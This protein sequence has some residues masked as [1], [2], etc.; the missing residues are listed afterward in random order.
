MSHRRREAESSLELL[1]DTICDTLSSILF[2]AVLV[3][4]MLRMTSKAEV[5]GS[6]SQVSEVEQLDLERQQ[7]ELQ[8][9]IETLR[10]AATAL[11]KPTD[12]VEPRIAALSAELHERRRIHQDLLQQ[13][14]AILD[15]IGNRQASINEV[16]R[17]IAGLMKREKDAAKRRDD[18]K[19]SLKK[20]IASRSQHVEYSRVR[21]TGKQ[22]IQA[23]LRYGRFYIW[24]KHG[25]SGQRLGLN[26]D[27]F[28]VLSENAAEVRSTPMPFAGTVAS[29]T[30]HAAQQLVARLIGFSPDRDYIGVLVWQDSFE[31]FRFLKKVLVQKGF[32]YRLIPA[33]DGDRFN[34]H[35][36]SRDGVQ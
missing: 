15:R 2:V 3:L 9:L 19:D 36:I 29:D 22:E 14:L 26:T 11:D 1:M 10:Q 32:E 13:R 33:N 17:T 28:V 27:E 24:H 8:G 20:E 30:A 18:L 12:L 4:V 35:G 16:A 6:A 34:D 5:E 25:P 31:Q 23:V 7:Q 21:Q